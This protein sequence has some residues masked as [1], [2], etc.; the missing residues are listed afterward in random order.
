VT[1]N[2]AEKIR[3]VWHLWGH[4]WEIEQFK[5]WK[6]LEKILGS[7]KNRKATYCTNEELLMSI[8]KT[9]SNSSKSKEQ[10]GPFTTILHSNSNCIRDCLEKM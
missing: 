10:T 4:S 1:L 6:S 3:G 7:L 2:H 5:L 8:K 9:I